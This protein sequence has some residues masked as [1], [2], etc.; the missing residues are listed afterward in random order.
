ML[1]FLAPR[2][3]IGR[4][5]I[6]LAL[7]LSAGA[8]V[9][10]LFWANPLAPLIVAGGLCAAAVAIYLYRRPVRA[11]C[12]ALFLHLAPPDFRIDII[13]DLLVHS[14]TLIAL[15][16]CLADAFSHKRPFLW[17]SVCI[18]I[19]LYMAWGSISLLWASD[20][21]DGRRKLVAYGIGLALLLLISNQVRSLGTLDSFMSVL[22][23]SGWIRVIGGIQAALFTNYQFGERLK[24]LGENENSLGLILI[25]MLPGV[26]WPVLRTEGRKRRIYMALSVV[27]ILF[28]LVLVALSGSR[29]S[30]VSLAIVLAAFC[31]SKAVR[32]WG[33]IGVMVILGTLAG[34]PFILDGLNKRFEEGEGGDLGGR[35]ELWQAS[36]LL[37]QDHP[38]T[39][40]GIGNGPSELHWYI[41][42][43]SSDPYKVMRTEYPSHNPLLEVTVDTGLIG[44]LIYISLCLSAVWQFFRSRG[45]P[46][47][48]EAPLSYYFPLVLC[49]V[50]GFF[51]SWIKAG[52]VEANP[53]SFLVLALLIVPYQLAYRPLF[54][55]AG[56]RDVKYRLREG[57]FLY[58]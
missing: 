24:A 10:P 25:V 56:Q 20:A 30:A 55:A 51:A 7:M 14:A 33:M 47:A 48:R 1:S 53:L 6:A 38:W 22:R 21:D 27:Y 15:I 8:C 50:A 52:G 40:V 4:R 36:W 13:F 35:E 45:H 26:I 3:V 46:R 18:L 19:A 42:M 2:N 37:M 11:L 49:V 29:G 32:P 44:M 57:A 54:Q 5:D 28:T 23:W 41:P 9:A 34:A 17:N 39:G 16:A 58:Q 31:L 12:I 43:V